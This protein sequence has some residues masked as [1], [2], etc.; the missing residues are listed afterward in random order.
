MSIVCLRLYVCICLYPSIEPIYEYLAE[1]NRTKSENINGKLLQCP[2][3]AI[4][5]FLY[6][7][8]VRGND[9]IVKPSIFNLYSN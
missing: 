6:L 8:L 7:V 2:F 1:Y 4:R 3:D 5:V 9:K